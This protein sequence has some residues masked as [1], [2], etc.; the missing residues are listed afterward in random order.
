MR[1][2]NVKHRGLRRLIEAGDRTGLPAA[3]ITKVLDILAFLQDMASADELR[4][5]AAWKPH[6]MRGDRKGTWALHVTGNWR[7]TFLI[8]RSQNEIFDL[9][10]EDYH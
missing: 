5:L 6:Q 10:Y 4:I 3:V 8:D 7:I 9:D 1:I 2:R